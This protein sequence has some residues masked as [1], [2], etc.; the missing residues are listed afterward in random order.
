M[1]TKRLLFLV[2]A[3]C[4]ASGVKAQFY[5][6]ADDIYYYVQ[7]YNGKGGFVEGTDRMKY[8]KNGEKVWFGAKGE[9]WVRIFNFDGKKACCWSKSHVSSVKDNF[10]NNP[11][12]YEDAIETTEY[13]VNFISCSSTEIIYKG[14]DTTFI[15]SKD[16]SMLTTIEEF[17]FNPDEIYVR[18]YK[19]VDK[20]YFKTGRSR[21]PS[22]TM[23]E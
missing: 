21:T 10:K 23:Y 19:K 20:S 7:I 8:A 16:R 12:Y 14:G 2:M 17:W 11:N 5:D 3:I 9:D 15:F 6:S 18:F 1:K 4:L 22:G 13:N